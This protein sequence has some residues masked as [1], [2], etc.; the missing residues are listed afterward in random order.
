MGQEL[1]QQ[2]TKCK[3]THKDCCSPGSRWQA[4][5]EAIEGLH[6]TSAIDLGWLS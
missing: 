5:E 4:H 3:P 1:Q 6:A 2:E